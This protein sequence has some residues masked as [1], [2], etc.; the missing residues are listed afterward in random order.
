VT[1][2]FIRAHFYGG[3]AGKASGKTSQTVNTQHHRAAEHEAC[4][5]AF[6]R[7]KQLRSSGSVG[8]LCA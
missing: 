7:A 3:N 6:M 4:E 2:R 8:G 1:G 5:R